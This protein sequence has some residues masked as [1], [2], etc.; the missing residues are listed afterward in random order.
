MTQLTMQVFPGVLGQRIFNEISVE[1]WQEWLAHQTTLINEYRLNLMDQEARSF[2]KIE[3]EKF[4]FGG[5]SDKPV[6]FV[7]AA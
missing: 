1:R 5:G 6:Q 3:M 2:L 4:L 7:E